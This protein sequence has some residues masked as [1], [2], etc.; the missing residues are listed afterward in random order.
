MTEEE[1]VEIARK[2]LSQSILDTGIDM[3]LVYQDTIRTEK[4]W[5]F[6]Y[7]SSDFLRTGNHAS[8]LAGNAPILVRQNGEVIRLPT[9]QS[10]EKSL[11]KIV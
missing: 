9:Y 2:I 3:E 8:L 4:G 11:K 7:E 1:A 10:I 6:F 5:I